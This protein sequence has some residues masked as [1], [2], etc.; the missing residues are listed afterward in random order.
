MAKITKGRYQVRRFGT[1]GHHR[2]VIRDDQLRDEPYYYTGEGAFP[3]SYDRRPAR[4][5]FDRGDAEVEIESLA[6]REPSLESEQR[7]TFK[8]EVTTLGGPDLEDVERLLRDALAV[9]LRQVRF[10]PDR[11]FVD[12]LIVIDPETV[13]LCPGDEA[14]HDKRPEHG[15]T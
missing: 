9:G 10:R 15:A 14:V 8:I 3:W 6:R 5:F 11:S 12:S 13:R 2:F 7:L 1:A 4:L